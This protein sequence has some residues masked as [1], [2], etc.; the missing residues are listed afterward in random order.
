MA[1][2]EARPLAAPPDADMYP[3]SDGKIM[4]ETGLHVDAILY[5]LATL[6]NWF[7]SHV[8]V[9]VG[10]NMF[11]YYQ[12][13]D[14]SKRL[15]P[16]L[17]VVRGL[18]A[19]PEPSFKIWE[20]GRPPTFVL[21]V[22]SP[23]TEK[24][25]R[26]EKQALYASMGVEEYWRFAPKGF[27]QDLERERVR[28]VGG[29][30]QGLGYAPLESAPDGSIRSEVLGLDIRADEQPETRHLL[31]F[32]DP[33]TGQDLLTFGELQ[34]ARI[35]EAAGRREAETKLRQEAASRR[36]AEGKLRQEA[37]SRREAERLQREAEN[38]L[39]EEAA[40]R[41][42]AERAQREAERAERAATTAKRDAEVEVA[43]LRAQVARLK[44]G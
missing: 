11:V 26:D 15:T 19:L 38:R 17:F 5:A 39:R 43:R 9:Q 10:A 23:S 1:I 8:R 42:K 6:R 20:A 24:R 13:G 12:E 37:A 3:Y 25:D 18:E 27:L 35:E 33:E 44:R 14:A 22:A 30:L 7:A 21:E 28:L 32:R 31:R 2:T 4:A 36:E 34:E 29:V 40:S 41:G 16:D